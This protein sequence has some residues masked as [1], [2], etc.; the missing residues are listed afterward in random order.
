VSVE[1]ID[2]KDEDPIG[3]CIDR[4]LDVS[5]EVSL[6]SGGSDRRADDSTRRH[7]EIRHEAQ[8]T[9]AGVLEL[10]ALNET[11]A[12]RLRHVQRWSH[13]GFRTVAGPLQEGV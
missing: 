2:D 9:V 11:G 1:L 7:V 8:G 6:G 4:R 12:D 13:V 5:H 3:V 10:D